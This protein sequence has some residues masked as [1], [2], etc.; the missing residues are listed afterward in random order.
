MN[1]NE[2]IFL[3]NQVLGGNVNAFRTI[4]DLHKDKAFN[5]AYRMCGSRED[6]E[7]IIQDSFL[8]AY[9]SLRE[10]R[11][12]SLFATWFYRIV[13]NTSVSFIR[14]K[15]EIII[16]SGDCFPDSQKYSDTNYFE[17]VSEEEHK[18]K[19]VNYALGKLSEEERGLISL[20]YY[21]EHTLAEISEI[22]CENISNIKVKLH[23][24]RKKMLEI[25]TGI[26]NRKVI[27]K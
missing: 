18:R 11:M 24:S 19:L 20:F 27:A 22:T 3:V 17:S 16:L 13:Y 2:D 26:N 23:R 10:F 1:K 4:I 25:L 12:D 15:K 7:E 6:A 8:K 5:L 14:A 9:R 21:D